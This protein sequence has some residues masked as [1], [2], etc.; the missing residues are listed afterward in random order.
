M[1]LLFCS[2]IEYFPTKTKLDI[3]DVLQGNYL[4]KN[5]KEISDSILLRGDTK[6]WKV[7]LLYRILI[8][9]PLPDIHYCAS[10]NW[11]I[12]P[13]LENWNKNINPGSSFIRE[14]VM[15]N[16][17]APIFTLWLDVLLT[18]I[19][20]FCVWIFSHFI[21]NTRYHEYVRTYPLHYI[22]SILWIKI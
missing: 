6:N 8:C 4:I 3:D 9:L 16:K 18:P 11:K 14:K 10:T 13:L 15:C 12:N 20:Y 5:N 22:Y 21:P 17:Q 19:F 1:A 2:G 7:V